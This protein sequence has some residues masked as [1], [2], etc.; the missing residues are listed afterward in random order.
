[1]SG[2]CEK[3][4]G[5]ERERSAECEKRRGGESESERERGVESVRKGEVGRERDGENK[6][7]RKTKTTFHILH[8]NLL[9]H[10]TINFKFSK[11]VQVL[12]KVQ[13]PGKSSGSR[14]RCCSGLPSS[15]PSAWCPPYRASLLRH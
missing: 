3:G 4:R 1:M 13:V 15:L 2:E 5:R 12:E 11:K 6:Y 14:R 9:V 8:Q 7:L 10:P